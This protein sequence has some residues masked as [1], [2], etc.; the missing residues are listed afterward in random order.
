MATSTHEELGAC[1]EIDRIFARLAA[2]FRN[3][4][5]RRGAGGKEFDYIDSTMVQNRLDDAVGPSNW[6]DKY[7]II[8][9]CVYCEITII[10]PN[11]RPVTR[12]D[13]SAYDLRREGDSKEQS[14]SKVKKTAFSDAF[15]R[16]AVKFGI[17]RYLR[18]DYV[19]PAYYRRMA[20]RIRQAPAPAAAPADPP[21]VPR[22]PE[23]SA[24]PT[25]AEFPS[26][27]PRSPGRVGAILYRTLTSPP[28][29]DSDDRQLLYRANDYAREQEF[30]PRLVDWNIQ[31]V[32]EFWHANI[33]ESMPEP[34][35]AI[36]THVN[37]QSADSNT[38]DQEFK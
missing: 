27:R 22:R 4:K 34:L 28:Y 9:T 19:T 36:C 30:P 1:E 17:G 29:G 37:P 3:P 18:P 21:A 16:A 24:P 26:R 10:L 13:C 6:E 5:R 35:A 2:P 11:G 38:K 23:P 15:K 20:E 33:E 7:H 31:Q 12:G 14:N 25:A 32:Q 8:D